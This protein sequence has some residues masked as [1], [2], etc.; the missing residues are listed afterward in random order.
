MRLEINPIAFCRLVT[1]DLERVPGLVSAA[2]AALF[3]IVSL[4]WFGTSSLRLIA[5]VLFI[6]L[7][8]VPTPAALYCRRSGLFLIFRIRLW[9][10]TAAFVLVPHGLVLSD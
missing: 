4:A 8:P 5:A 9:P 10:A 6:F 2:T 3:S 7:P 1:S